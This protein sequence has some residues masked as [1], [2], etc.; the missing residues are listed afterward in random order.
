MS[1]YT[2]VCCPCS[3]AL[4]HLQVLSMMI[5]PIDREPAYLQT[6]SYSEI[7]EYYSKKE[8][9]EEEIKIWWRIVDE[10]GCE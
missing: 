4:F 10:N 3:R 9:V 5:M 7:M 6:L 8:K 2:N 1:R